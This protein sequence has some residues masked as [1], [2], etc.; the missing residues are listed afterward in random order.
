MS[1]L[2]TR[3][4]R[5]RIISQ[6]FDHREFMRALSADER[7]VIKEAREDRNPEDFYVKNTD[8]A[9]TISANSKTPSQH[10]RQRG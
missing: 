8:D 6:N 2:D 3:R 7:E 10:E 1:R 4:E 5:W 9:T